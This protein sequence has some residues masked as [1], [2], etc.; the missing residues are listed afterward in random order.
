MSSGALNPIADYNPPVVANPNRWDVV[1]I[2]GQTCPG[3]CEIAGFERKWKW[4]KKTGKGAQGTTCTYTGKPAVEGELIFF[5]WTGLH[6]VQWEIFRPLFQ[7]D[8]TKQQT[9]AIDIFHPSLADL[10]IKAVVIE[11]ISPIRHIGHNLYE[12]RVK[13]SEY[14]PPPKAAAVATPAG[15]KA[16]AGAG[17][18]SNPA[19][20]SPTDPLQIKIQQLYNQ[21]VQP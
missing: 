2:A 8:P 4:D 9:Q 18:G 21:F 15:A 20:P 12:C 1:T 13:A 10:N 5:L 6:F 14:V 16:A 11:S 3:Y 7:Y 19:A 17:S